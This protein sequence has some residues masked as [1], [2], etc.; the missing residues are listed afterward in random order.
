MQSAIQST[1]CSIETIMFE[2]TDGLAGP[3]IVNRFGKPCTMM[4]R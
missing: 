3:V 1:C 4:P 2:N